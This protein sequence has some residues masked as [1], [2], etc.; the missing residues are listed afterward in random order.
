MSRVA[1]VAGDRDDVGLRIE[2]RTTAY[3]EGTIVFPVRP[4]DRRFLEI[5]RRVL[6]HVFCFRYTQWFQAATFTISERWDGDQPEIVVTRNGHHPS[7]GSI[8]V[9]H[10]WG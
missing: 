8:V 5:D 10:S 6:H 2:H 4:G 1:L 9:G 3:G 7:T